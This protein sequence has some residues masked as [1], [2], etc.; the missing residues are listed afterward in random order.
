MYGQYS[1]ALSNQER[2]I[3]AC[4]WY[5]S[6]LSRSAKRVVRYFRLF[7]VVCSK[8]ATVHDFALLSH[9]FFQKSRIFIYVFQDFLYWFWIQIQALE[10]MGSSHHM[11]VVH[12]GRMNYRS[13][14]PQT[15]CIYRSLLHN[16]AKIYVEINSNILCLLCQKR[17]CLI[18]KAWDVRIWMRILESFGSH[19]VNPQNTKLLPWFGALV[20]CPNLFTTFLV[21]KFN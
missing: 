1:R 15:K 16:R 12:G 6:Q 20:Q 19:C 21:C 18:E 11:S 17:R 8:F 9:L 7:L 4:V 10:N 5:S 2:V 13:K 14:I 3:V